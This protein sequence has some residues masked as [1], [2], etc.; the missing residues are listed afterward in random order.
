MWTNSR[1]GRPQ[2]A[3]KASRPM[4]PKPLMPILVTLS[5]SWIDGVDAKRRAGSL[6]S[7]LQQRSAMGS[8]ESY[9]LN[10]RVSRSLS[11]L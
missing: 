9:R 1:S 4:R 3:R 5:Y 10:L 7:W 11:F 2:P 8:T 6:V